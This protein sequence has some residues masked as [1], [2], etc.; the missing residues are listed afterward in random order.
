MCQWTDRL[1]NEIRC[2]G[3]WWMCL[4]HFGSPATVCVDQ[5]EDLSP[6]SSLFRDAWIGKDVRNKRVSDRVLF[7]SPAPFSGS[8]PALLAARSCRWPKQF[9]KPPPG[10]FFCG[11]PPL[12][13]GPL[14][15]PGRLAVRLLAT[16]LIAA[17]PVNSCGRG[18]FAICA[19]GVFFAA[20]AKSA[21]SAAWPQTHPH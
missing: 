12:A 19:C 10:R 17:K 15:L 11:R 7:P 1:R 2:S 20:G 8:F 6:Q 21:E 13:P 9:A 3:C 18:V 16:A 4:A 14:C 5:A